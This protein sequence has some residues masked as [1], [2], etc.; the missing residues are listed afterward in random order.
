MDNTERRAVRSEP[1]VHVRERLRHL[2]RD[3][4]GLWP[5]D[6]RAEVDRA[7]AQ[8]GKRPALDMLDHRVRLAVFVGRGFENLGDTRVIELRLNARLVEKTRQKRSIVDVIAPDGLDDDR[9]LRP[10]NPRRG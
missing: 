7:L 2:E 8:I 9:S 10:F 1:L 6:P 5:T 4:D 3:R